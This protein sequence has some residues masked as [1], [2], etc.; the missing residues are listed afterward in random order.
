MGDK[1][2]IHSSFYLS[3]KGGRGSGSE[4]SAAVFRLGGGQG[5]ADLGRREKGHPM[6]RR[7]K[8]EDHCALPGTRGGKAGTLQTGCHRSRTGYYAKGEIVILP[9]CTKV[10]APG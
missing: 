8:H 9:T 6:A 5:R 1:N 3:N 4:G 10:G 2:A 7:V